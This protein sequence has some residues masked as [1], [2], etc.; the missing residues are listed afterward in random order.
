MASILISLG[1]LHRQEGSASHTW[2]Y[3]ALL[4]FFHDFCGNIIR[5]HSF[6]RT[7]CGKLRQIPIFGI[8]CNI[9]FIQYIDQFRE[10]RGNPHALFVLHALHSLNHDFFYNHSQVFPDLAILYLV[11]IHEYSHKWSLSVTGHQGNQL[12]LDGLDSASYF[13]PKPSLRHLCNDLRIQRLAAFFALL[14]YIIAD[15]LTADVYKRRQM[16]QSK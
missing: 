8:F 13:I 9:I 7:F 5:N 4:Q 2:I 10:C 3:I 16:R 12:I 14:D 11:Q 1:I 6:C 15:L